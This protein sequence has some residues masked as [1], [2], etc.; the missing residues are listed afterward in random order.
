M[1]KNLYDLRFGIQREDGYVSH[2]WRLWITRSGDVYLAKRAYGGIEKYSFHVSG[3]CRDAFTKEHGAPATMLDRAMLKWMRAQTPQRN[4]GQASRVA[5]IA[6]PTDY[7]SRINEICTKQI[8]W[9]PA[10]PP[11]GA[12]IVELMFTKESKSAVLLGFQ[13]N[14]RRLLSYT[15]LP[16]GEAFVLSYNQGE[17]INEDLRVPTGKGSVFP[18]LLFSTNDPRDTGRPVRITFGPSP[19][20]GDALMLREIGGYAEKA[21]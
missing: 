16:K 15:L 9:I 5:W 6:F 3:V 10:A 1:A 21:D 7:L 18:D 19:K 12:T 20:N 14:N 2:M 17:W 4:S 13:N 8:L 11:G